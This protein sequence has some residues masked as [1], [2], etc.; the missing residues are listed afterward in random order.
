VA[1]VRGGSFSAGGWPLGVI[2]I[3]ALVLLPLL[4]LPA[5]GQGR[6][7][8]FRDPDDGAFDMSTFMATSYGFLPVVSPITE[9]ALGLGAAGALAFI[10]RPEGW[11]IDEARAAFDAGERMVR[12]SVSAAFGMY[13]SDESWAAGAAHLGNWGDGRWRYLG[14]AAVMELNLSVSGSAPNGQ[15]VL[16]DY[17]LEGWFL[18]QSIRYTLGATDWSVGANFDYLEMTAA[19]PGDRL[20]EASPAESD[21]TLGGL[22]FALRYD[23]RNSPFSPDRG[24]FADVALR[25]KDDA[26][27]SDFEYWTTKGMFHGYLIPTERLALGLRIEGEVAGEEAPFW[28]R[29]GV[30]LRGVARGRYTGNAAGVVET[31]VRFDLNRRWSLVGFGGAGWTLMEDEDGVDRWLG[32]GGGGFRYLLA[33][34]FGL[35]GGLDVAYGKDGWA[36]YVTM[37]SAWPGF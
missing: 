12:P 35:R 20:P 34:A 25:K 31:E 33:R 29:P 15:E 7:S 28:A 24:I 10:H 22:G 23:S 36:F 4:P 17:G 9:P 16:F 6:L 2:P 11:N 21:A 3:L 14:A 19:F 5:A 13:T 8:K 1:L 30:Y 26:L 18:T 32:G 37:G 27:G